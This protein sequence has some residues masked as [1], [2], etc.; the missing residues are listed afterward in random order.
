MRAEARGLNLGRTSWHY[1][2]V[3][4]AAAARPP[5]ARRCA[6]VSEKVAGR[7][8]PDFSKTSPTPRMPAVPSRESS[9]EPRPVGT[10][11]ECVPPWRHTLSTR[12]V[13]PTGTCRAP[14]TVAAWWF[15]V[16]REDGTTT[17][18]HCR[19]GKEG[20]S[21]VPRGTGGASPPP[22]A[23][24]IIVIISSRAVPPRRRRR[25]RAAATVR[26][27]PPARVLLQPPPPPPPASAGALAPAHKTSHIYHEPVLQSVQDLHDSVARSAGV[28]AGALMPPVRESR[29]SCPRGATRIARVCACD[30]TRRDEKEK[31]TSMFLLPRPRRDLPFVLAPMQRRLSPREMAPPRRRRRDQPR[32]SSERCRAATDMTVGD[33]V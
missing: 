4:R 30:K 25:P 6:R 13:L 16:R 27:P 2:E 10:V 17:A 7:A 20:P 15:R 28:R 19:P 23:C 31:R 18:L 14:A 1:D 26:A 8:M 11:P 32:S 5:Q 22:P 33:G 21:R 12:T 9:L 24:S 3:R 29:W